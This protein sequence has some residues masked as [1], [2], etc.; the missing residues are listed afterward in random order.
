MDERDDD[1][2][3]L[4]AGVRRS[5]RPGL[6]RTLLKL[7][8]TVVVAGGL[9]A[10]LL[11]PWVGGPAV[12]A[13]QSTSLLGDPPAELTDEQPAG[14]TVVL[15]AD[16]TPMTYFYDENRQPVA[17]GDIAQVMKDALVAIEDA[18][19]Y[20][21]NGLDVQGT[22]RALVKNIVAGAVE[23]GGSTLTQQ[24][25]KQTLL[26]TATTAEAGRAATERS[27]ARKLRE[28]RLAL[29]LEDL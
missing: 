18:R 12:A 17:S 25:V 7:V 23:E 2:P 3:E 9:V 1:R 28:A 13:Q 22:A 4:F 6:A 29:A 21:H 5:P 16:G 11:L 26:Q 15:A 14:N 10:G 8:L 24:L 20:D 19:F 27:V